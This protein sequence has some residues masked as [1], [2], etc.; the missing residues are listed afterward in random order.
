MITLAFITV[1]THNVP[2]SYQASL[3]AIDRLCPNRLKER[4]EEKRKEKN[5][6]LD[7]EQH[8]EGDK[9]LFGEACVIDQQAGPERSCAKEGTQTL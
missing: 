8:S 6:P 2:F 7:V 1:I 5:V 4:R 9:V 3:K